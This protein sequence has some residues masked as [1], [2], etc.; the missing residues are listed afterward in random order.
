[1][2]RFKLRIHICSIGYDEQ[3][4]DLK[5]LCL[6]ILTGF[7]FVKAVNIY[8]TQYPKTFLNL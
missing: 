3:E 2:V 7:I 1:M 4:K 5:M 6:I 8:K